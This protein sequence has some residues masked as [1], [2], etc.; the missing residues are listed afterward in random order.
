MMA[1]LC[2][3]EELKMTAFA[4]FCALFIRI[5]SPTG[6]RIWVLAGRMAKT[7]RELLQNPMDK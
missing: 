7:A 5:R 6:S 2:L 4:F 3:A 1:C